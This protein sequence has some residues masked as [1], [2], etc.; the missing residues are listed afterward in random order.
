MSD[1]VLQ[2]R[3]LG[4]SGPSGSLVRGLDLAVDAG[5]I[6]ALVGESGSGKSITGRVI[7]GLLPDGLTASGDVVLAG[8]QIVGRSERALRELRGPGA[9]MIFQEPQTALNPSQRIWRQIHEVLR[10][11]TR[12]SRRDGRARAIELLSS[13]GIP[14]PEQRAEWYPHQLSGGQRQRVVIALALAAKPALLIADEPTTALDVTVQAQILSLLR[15][16]R[17]S[18]G[19]GILLV[20]HDLGVV[21]DVA[22]RVVVLRAGES[23]EQAPVDELF[24]RPRHE[25]TRRLL[26]AVP[27]LDSSVPTASGEPAGGTEYVAP[28]V[29][30]SGVTVRYPGARRPALC[31]VDLTVARD[32]VVGV[33]GESGS[34]KSTL[35]RTVLGLIAPAEGVV[36]RSARRVALVHQDPY[37]ALDPRWSV[38]RIVGEPLRLAGEGHR[39]TEGRVAE[40]LDAVELP[41]GTGA[42][43]PRELSGGQRQRVAFARALASAPELLVADEPTSALDVSV[44]AGVLTLFSSL[45]SEFGFAA[46]FVTHDLAVVS[47]VAS[48]VLVLRAG[49]VVEQGPTGTVLANPTSQYARDLVAAVPLPDPVR[50]RARRSDAAQGAGSGTV[51]R[52]RSEV[53]PAEDPGRSAR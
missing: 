25:Y 20:T 36:E 14:E 47:E 37:A 44:Q 6:V 50:Q 7:L 15:D 42:R 11:H 2:I 18:S 49:T 33:V 39:A 34:G 38:T 30:V 9:A 51:R 12:V 45:Q 53:A 26:A 1:P 4:I 8:E 43:H 17:D 13:V 52:A 40:L 24:A 28:V 27:V 35:G 23:V 48:R 29:S 10:A 22:D 32:E 46:L 21:A 41:S 19:V 5:E 16:L 31:G 3:G